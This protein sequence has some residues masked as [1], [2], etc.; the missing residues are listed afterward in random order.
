MK[1]L[2]EVKNLSFT[3]FARNGKGEDQLV[4]A[5]IP[6][7]VIYMEHEPYACTGRRGYTPPLKN[8]EIKEWD[9]IEYSVIEEDAK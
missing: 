2:R 5:C 8:I 3:F 1:I 6:N 4:K 9:K 7:A